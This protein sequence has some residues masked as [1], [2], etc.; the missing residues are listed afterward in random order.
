ML[1]FYLELIMGLMSGL[2]FL[3]ALSVAARTQQV[4][5]R[6]ESPDWKRS[7]NRRKD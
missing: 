3:G 4:L 6:T 7:P 1:T 5:V 2:L